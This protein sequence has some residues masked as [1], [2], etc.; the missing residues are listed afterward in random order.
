M[1]LLMTRYKSI[2]RKIVITLLAAQSVGSAGFIVTA[3]VNTIVGDKLSGHASWAGVPSA[4]YQFGAALAA[5]AWG[6]GMEKLGRRG[7]LTLGLLLGVVGS[8]LATG[9]INS[10][11]FAVFLIAMILMG[12]ANSAL[13]LARFAAAEVHEPSERGRAISNVV[14]GGTVGAVFGPVLVGPTGKLALQFNWQELSGP[15]AAS[16][17][18]FI[19][20]AIIIFLWL[21][22]DPRD[23]G[24]EITARDEKN[25]TVIAGSTRSI[26]QILSQPAAIVAVSAMVFGQATMVML[27]VITSLHLREHQHELSSI[28]YVISSHVFGMYAFSVLSG[29]LADR[30]GRAPVIIVGAVTLI[31]ACIA[32]PLSPDILPVSVAL[33]LLGLGWNFCYVGGSSLLADQLS[34]AE[35]AKTQGFNDLLIGLTSAIG[36]LGSGFVFAAVGYGVMGIVG[37]AAA[38][39]PLA[40]T[41]WWQVQRQTVV[42]TS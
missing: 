17:V 6:Y 8:L 27:M 21:R 13:Q 37:A 35:R 41:V 2:A 23:I 30:W 34:P 28:A 9:A 40:L 15:Y 14:V 26:P 18:L 10:G 36:S 19:I 1:T 4:V 7:G 24:R 38:L 5:F 11:S 25:K 32:A 42:A 29:R 39:I 16:F 12:T 33:F 22:P 3:T 20:A 31:I